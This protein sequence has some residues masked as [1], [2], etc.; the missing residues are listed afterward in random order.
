MDCAETL[1]LLWEYLDGELPA[2]PADALTSHL[3]VCRLCWVA[4]R[5]DGAFLQRITV[6]GLAV[7]APE[8]LRAIV[9]QR[10]ELG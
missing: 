3:K 9:E 4:C 6:A 8:P 1:I 7:R 2:E 5:V 10:L